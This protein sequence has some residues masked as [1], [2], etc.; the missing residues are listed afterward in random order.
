MTQDESSGNFI[1]SWD[2]NPL[3]FPKYETDA[4]YYVEST[5]WSEVRE[6]LVRSSLAQKTTWFGGNSLPRSAQRLAVHMRGCLRL[7]EVP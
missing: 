7:A 6:V 3:T 5:K 4:E 2:G 1:P